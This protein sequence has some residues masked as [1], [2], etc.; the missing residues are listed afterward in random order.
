VGKRPGRKRDLPVTK[1]GA[2]TATQEAL[3]GHEGIRWWRALRE[4]IRGDKGRRRGSQLG[5]H[6]GRLLFN[7]VITDEQ[8]GAALDWLKLLQD[9]RRIVLDCPAGNKISNMEPRVPGVSGREYSKETI[10]AIVD[11]YKHC[12]AAIESGA[13][14]AETWT[15]MQT[16]IVEDCYVDW[17]R[18]RLVADGLERLVAVMGAR[19]KK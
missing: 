12:R 11:K 19:R 14:G 6:L 1:V 4:C 9:E 5:S 16:L 7:G 17:S 15:A 10:E 3:S 8:Y 2:S 18:Q 13:R